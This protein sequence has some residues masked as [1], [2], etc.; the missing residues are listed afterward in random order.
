MKFKNL[1]ITGFKSFSEKTSFYIENGLTGIVGPN[2]CG[3]S[4][5]VEALR[6]CMGENSAKS[7]RGSGMEDVIFSGT[8]NRPSKNISEVSLYLDNINKEGPDQYNEFDEISVRRKI[9]KDK[10]SKYFI[11]DKE[12]RARDVQTFFADLSTGAHSPSLIS[13][14]RIGQLVTAKPIERKAILEEAAG[15]SG[16]HA[17]RQEAETRL[18]AAENNLKRADELK[19]QQ[20]KQLD[21][22]KKQ[23][24]EATRYKEISKL[25]K[26]IEAGLYFLKIREIEKD[27][28]KILDKLN[29]LD[30]EISAVNI[31]F[32]HNNTLLEE[33]NKKLAPLRDK[34]M[35]SAAS[36]QK[37]NLDMSN[38]VEEEARV[39]SL[40]G[41]LERSIKTVDSDL[42][43][44]KSISLDADL[45]EKRILK[46]KEELLNTENKLLE[47]Q[48]SSSKEL[49]NSK[50][51]LEDQQNQ[52]DIMLDQ[53]E[54]DIDQDKKLK[55][56][57]FQKLKQLVKKITLSQEQYAEKYGKNKSIE[58]DSIKRKERIK[59][60]DIELE[61]WRNLKTNS[62][63]MKS[64]LDNR[65]SKLQ[66]EISEN[67]KNP[68]RIAT[69]KGQNLQNLENIKKRN[70][71][72]ESELTAAEKKYNAINENLKEIQLKLTDL[73]ENKARNEATIEGIEN[74]KKDLL[75]SVKNEL[76][77]ENESSILVQSDLNDIE[78]ENLP[79]IEEQTEK[80]EKIKKTRDSLGSVNL[81]A[82]EETKK[83]EEEIKKMEDDRADL[84]SAI[85]K[86]KTSIDELNQKGRERLL[87]AF[88]KVNRKFN[89]VYTKLFS[90]GTAK[91]ELVDSDDPLEAGLEMYV[92]P[93]GKR[94]Q[95]ITLL[96]GG[97]QA[98]TALSLVFAVFLVNPSP[99]CV[100]DEVDAPLDDANVTRFCAL[101]DELT[102]ITKTKFIIITH[103]ALT[104]SRM[105][106]LYGVTM[107]EQGVSQL[108]AV[109]LQKAEELV[110]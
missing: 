70:H 27:K 99:I 65:K 95:S 13:Q 37:L 58:S 101:L 44:E 92:S 10:G 21:N 16:I 78:V 61:N 38:L 15:I 68:E 74:R 49:Q 17:R 96:S 64:E 5:I 79:S 80:V 3:K 8:S 31:D 19:K 33:E 81:R 83:Y 89:E 55:K 75:Y 90:G 86:L 76:S 87:E 43:R 56:E 11:N 94:L 18:N 1:E 42:E 30:D 105:H 72:I 66:I 34:K 62:E 41:K 98:L 52:L 71:E 25:I 6:W 50:S 22:L 93:P 91:I 40:Q 84:Y 28:K 53:I 47:V 51:I 102:K 35:E 85:I 12:V 77:I 46:E 107:A 82:D 73:K 4:N 103:H 109:D 97:E 32:N 45:N 54:K 36:L 63:K 26:K 59:N 9:E 23:A 67:Q 48:S 39:K 110:A 108:V 29:E 57:T 14:G 24:E 60:I 106:R 69:T 2:G 88:T 100:L 7:M 104:M 20:Q